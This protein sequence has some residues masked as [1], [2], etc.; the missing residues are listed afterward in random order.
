MN[1]ASLLDA[2]AL[3][4]VSP[5]KVPLFS[6]G[7]RV[8]YEDTDAAGVV[9]YANYLKFF[10]RCRTEWVRAMGFGQSALAEAYDVVF[11][12]RHARADYRKPARLDDVLRVDLSIQNVGRTQLVLNQRVVK[13]TETGE[14]E[15]VTGEVKLVCVRVST[16]KPAAIPAVLLAKF[17]EIV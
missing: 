4:G 6:I 13:V 8:Y 1:E 5:E 17:Q 12:V 2:S 9:Y 14:E 7:A 10:E 15:L 16:F 11:V 3:S